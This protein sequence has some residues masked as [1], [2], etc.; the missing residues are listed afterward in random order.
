M[1][2]KMER[3]RRALVTVM[4]GSSWWLLWQLD[5]GGWWWN[6]AGLVELEGSWLKKE[7]KE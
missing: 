2:E 3:E 4:S 7:D 1:K 5:G 6:K